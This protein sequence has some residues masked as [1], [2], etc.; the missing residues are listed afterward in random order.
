MLVV[1][2]FQL[3]RDVVDVLNLHDFGIGLRFAMH[4]HCGVVQGMVEAVA[5][6]TTHQTS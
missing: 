3:C 4:H 1:E 2:V 6:L 5:G